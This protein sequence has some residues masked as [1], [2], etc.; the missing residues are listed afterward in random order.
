MRY[1]KNEVINKV[2]LIGC[3]L[4]DV[5]KKVYEISVRI[6]NEV[7][8]RE[9]M[10]RIDLVIKVVKKWLGVDKIGMVSIA[11]IYLMGDEEWN[12][13]H[14]LLMKE[15]DLNEKRWEKGEQGYDGYDNEMIGDELLAMM[16]YVRRDYI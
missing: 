2:G 14:G 10:D 7:V 4:I 6:D 16:Y 5:I 13:L 3:E 9:D 12:E 15:S 11:M 8:A 1:N